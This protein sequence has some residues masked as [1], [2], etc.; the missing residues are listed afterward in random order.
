[1]IRCFNL[2]LALGLLLIFGAV[3]CNSTGHL[4][5]PLGLSYATATAVYTKGVAIT[6]NLPTT[7]EGILQ[8]YSVDPALPAGLVLATTTGGISGTPTAVTPKGTYIVTGSNGGGSTSATLTITVNDTAPAGLSYGVGTAFYTAGVVI[9]SDSPTSTGGTP[10]SYSVSPS[11]PT[12]LILD[13]T[14][15]IIS[16]TPRSVTATAIYTVTASNGSG[17]TAVAL[18]LTVTSAPVA[19]TIT[20]PPSVQSVT[21]GDPVTFTVTATGTA[22]MGYQ[23]Y[24]GTTPVGGNNP[25]YAITS[26]QLTDAGNYTVT[27]SN[28]TAPAATSTP[29][30]LTVNPVVVA[31]TITTY[32]ADQS[33]VTGSSGNFSVVATGSAPLSYQWHLDSV[34]VGTGLSTYASPSTTTT[35]GHTVTVTVTNAA[36]SVVSN[37]AALTVTAAPVAPIITTPP[38]A[39]SVTAG[40]PVTFTVAAGGTAPL[41]Y[42]WYQGT[43]P[44]GG[45]TPFYTISSA[46][47]AN[48]GSYTVTVSNGT[49][50]A[51]TSTAVQLTVNV[52]PVAPTITTGPANQTVLVGS[53]ATFTVAATGTAPLF[54]QW[55]LNG[56][57]V[58]LNS[59]TY[60]S[61][62]TLAAG[63]YDVTVTV[64][65]AVSSATSATVTLTVGPLVV[66]LPG[67]LPLSMTP[68]AA[69][70][71]TMGAPVS[72]PD[73]NIN[74]NDDEGPQH[75]VTISQNFY[76]GTYLLTQAQWK[77]VMGSN[78]SYF[79]TAGGGSGTDDLQRPV[80]QV[81]WNDIATSTTSPTYTCFLDWL[82][83]NMATICPLCPTNYEFRL[84]TEAEWEYACRAGTATRF[85]W[86]DYTDTDTTINGYAWYEGNDNTT[87]EPVGGKTPNAW[88]LY[89]MAGNVYEWCQ[90]WYDATYY[91]AASQ[92]DPVGPHTVGSYRV[93]RGGS[94]N[95]SS[96]NC[97]SA[98]RIDNDPD[99]RY[100]AVGFRV[101]LAPPR[102]L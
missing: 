5:A 87:T 67:S 102:T 62:A 52:A 17:S 53:G 39:Q 3:G 37:P 16:G 24:Q 14:T 44:V 74:G 101:V 27:V 76:M 30:A 46:Q 49:A 66:T 90:D 57:N 9:S 83:A 45:N 25:F 6:A 32:P 35:G 99:L 78:P 95:Y 84:P 55:T 93:L 68:I 51:A 82:N 70:T 15:G 29:V 73:Y 22:P 36:G 72:D 54:Y 96:G 28:G 11:L 23:W 69:G 41:S 42:Q 47:T 75:Q 91:T 21:V 19:P 80:E 94:W 33:V 13:A 48:A 71:F 4:S 100:D 86:G 59:A 64:T 97:R 65:N 12:G 20:T 50:P 34:N 58:G 88:G 38:T 81:S 7:A 1:M 18:A 60:T 98:Y 77:A 85:F 8:S 2:V 10:T 43:T 56:S 31:P 89:D 40:D 92:T 26:A 79:S 61:D 63:S